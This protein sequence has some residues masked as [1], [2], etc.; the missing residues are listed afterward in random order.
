MKAHI[1]G[2]ILSL[3]GLTFDDPGVESLKQSICRAQEAHIEA[4]MDLVVEEIFQK[5]SN[6]QEELT[7]DEW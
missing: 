6:N 2:T 3:A 4:A 1:S 7:F 5:Y